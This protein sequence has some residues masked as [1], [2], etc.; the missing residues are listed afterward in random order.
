MKIKLALAVLALATTSIHAASIDSSS[1]H[2][3]YSNMNGP[4]AWSRLSPEFAACGA[5][6]EQSPIDIRAENGSH[7]SPIKFAYTAG[8]AAM[9]NNGHTIQVNIANGGSIKLESDKFKL[10]QF[11]FHT[12]SEES[13][14]GKRYP[15]VAHLVHKADDGSLAVIAVLFKSGRENPALRQVFDQ[16]PHS[17]GEEAA[18]TQSFDLSRILPVERSYYA[19]SGSLTTPPCSE[20]VRWQVL[21]TPVEISPQQLLAFKKIY[22]MN[23]RPLQAVNGRVIS[24]GG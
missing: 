16:L 8:K 13:V 7:L 18:L 21:R 2:W 19:Y 22:K 1:K 15:L 12:P 3:D 6:K 5:G 11:H 14:N 23:A 24:S 10:V 4:G 9:V 17:P 20:G